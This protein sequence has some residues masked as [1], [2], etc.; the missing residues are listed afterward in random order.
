V[1]ELVKIEVTDIHDKIGSFKEYAN[2]IN[3]ALPV[4]NKITKYMIKAAR[5]AGGFY[6]E[7]LGT[8]GMRTDTSRHGVARSEK[9]QAAADVHKNPKTL[10]RWVKLDDVPIGTEEKYEA[11]CNAELIESSMQGFYDY[12][13]DKLP[14]TSE[15]LPDD[16]FLYNIWTIQ[17]GDDK[18]FF[19]HFPEIFMRNLLYYHTD[20]GDVVFDPFA[21]SGTTINC[22]NAIERDAYCYDLHPTREDIFQHDIAKGLPPGLPDEIDLAFIDPPYWKQAEGQYSKDTTDLGNMDFET[23]NDTMAIL[24]KELSDRKTKQV[25]I[26]IQPTQYANSFIWTDHIFDFD[27]MLPHYAIAMRYILPYSTQQ[28]NAQIVEVAKK[29]GNCLCLNRDLVVWHL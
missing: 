26:I 28:Y 16:I 22:C 10:Q 2:R 4:K 12:W 29:T 23:F 13:A 14:S 18:E 20:P 5:K 27:K 17:G 9:Q 3:A 24:L 21:G 1:N 6:A 7:I 15:P 25:A 19:G 11:Y 8:P